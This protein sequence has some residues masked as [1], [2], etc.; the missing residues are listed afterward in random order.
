MNFCVVS[1]RED[2]Q[3]NVE[4]IVRVINSTR[5]YPEVCNYQ[6]PQ[7][8]GSFL[9]RFPQF[10]KDRYA[11]DPHHNFNISRKNGEVG[12]WLSH[13]S[14][15]QYIVDNELEHMLVTED[16]LSITENQLEQINQEIASRNLELIML[17][18]WTACYYISNSGAKKVLENAEEGFLHHPVDFYLFSC[19][20]DEIV[21]GK[22]GPFIVK[23][24]DAF[25]SHLDFEVQNDT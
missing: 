14:V 24:N 19:V 12:C 1:V 4:S 21:N 10:T 5:H 8:R 7:S 25:G 15:W 6:D 16:D 13:I 2:R 17:G 20:E 22:I 11:S 9:V 3:E 18:G 23:Q